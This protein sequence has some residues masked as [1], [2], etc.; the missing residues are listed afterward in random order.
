MQFH[1]GE[2]TGGSTTLGGDLDVVVTTPNNGDVLTWNSGSSKWVNAAV[3]AGVASVFTRTGAVTATSG[4]YSISQITGGAPLA[5]PTF[6]GTVVLPSG[7]A[8][9]AP[10]LGTPVSG[11]LVNC[12]G[13]PGPT[14]VVGINTQTASYTAVLADAGK[15]VRMN[16]GSANTFTIPPNASVA[17]PVSTVITCRQIGAGVTTITAGAG[18]TIVSPTTGAI[19]RQYGTIQLIQ[20]ATDSWDLAGD[21]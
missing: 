10:A 17:F 12:T 18:V 2:E 15:F 9:I 14:S 5:S 6:T 3:V 13:F 11:N 20:V 19:A 7:Q 8:L 21:V 16:V 4:D 1:T